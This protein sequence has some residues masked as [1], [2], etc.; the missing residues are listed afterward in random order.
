MLR[1]AA[2]CHKP[3]ARL[4]AGGGQRCSRILA[5]SQKQAGLL[6]KTATAD[7][8]VWKQKYK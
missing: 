7:N 6:L 8:K 5:S 2:L 1:G 3:G 4:S